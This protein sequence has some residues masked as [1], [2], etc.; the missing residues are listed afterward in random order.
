MSGVTSASCANRAPAIRNTGT[1]MN[2]DL[3]VMVVSVH[4][5]RL[6]SRF[7]SLSG[8]LNEPVLETRLAESRVIVRNQR[9]LTHPNAVVPP[10]RVGDHLARIVERGQVP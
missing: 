7:R 8:S 9:S 6:Q 1:N 4:L 3:V 2:R 5:R 10:I